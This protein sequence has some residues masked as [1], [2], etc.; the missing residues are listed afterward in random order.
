MNQKDFVTCSFYASILIIA[1]V[2][3]SNSMCQRYTFHRYQNI[4]MGV[5]AKIGGV[6]VLYVFAKCGTRS[7]IKLK[8]Q[9]ATRDPRISSRRKDP[10]ACIPREPQ[11][12]DR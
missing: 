2:I 7:S 10:R 9:A 6:R 3:I 4:G 5:T 8:Y 1:K 12:R 11:I